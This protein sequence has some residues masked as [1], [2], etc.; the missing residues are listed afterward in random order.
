MPKEAIDLLS[1]DDAKKALTGKYLPLPDG[2]LWIQYFDGEVRI[3]DVYSY[4]AKLHLDN[5]KFYSKL[6]D[7]SFFKKIKVSNGVPYWDTYVDFDPHEVFYESTVIAPYTKLRFS[8]SVVALAFPRIAEQHALPGFD[9]FINTK[10]HNPP[11]VHVYGPGN[12]VGRFLLNG[13]SYKPKLITL[14]PSHIRKV[15]D[16]IKNHEIEIRK[17][18][19]LILKN[20]KYIPIGRKKGK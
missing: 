19:D 20:K 17:I 2:K 16:F 12:T 7:S 11:H 13:D 10:D 9:L 6:Y 1:E 18:Y 4:M 8:S 5:D 14:S 15:Q 3:F